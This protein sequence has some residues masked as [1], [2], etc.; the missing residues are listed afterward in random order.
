MI[1]DDIVLTLC[2][3]ALVQAF[4]DCRLGCCNALVARLTV[5][6]AQ[7]TAAR[8]SVSIATTNI[9]PAC[10]S[11]TSC[12]TTA[13]HLQDPCRRLETSCLREL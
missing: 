7:N 13:S 3:K 6:N 5:I 10:A 2:F 11:N 1:D 9:Q 12:S 8:Y 4:V